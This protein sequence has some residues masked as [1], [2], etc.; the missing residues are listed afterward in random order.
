MK[1]LKDFT[2][3]M[4][5]KE[6]KIG[7]DVLAWTE[8]WGCIARYIGGGIF[9]NVNLFHSKALAGHPIK[10]SYIEGVISWSK[11]DK[12]IFGSDSRHL[13]PP[14]YLNK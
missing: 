10:V 1:T 2:Y 4:I 5:N 8:E 11:I 14:Y 13:Q 12:S 3:L 6:P 7:E 9:V